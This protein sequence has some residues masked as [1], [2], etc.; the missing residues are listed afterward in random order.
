MDAIEKG[1]FVALD[2]ENYHLQP[3]NAE[4]LEVHVETI[5]VVWLEGSYSKSWKVAKKKEGCTLVDWL[6]SVPKSSVILFDFS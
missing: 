3:L 5:D 1:Q 4:V 6:D 2:V